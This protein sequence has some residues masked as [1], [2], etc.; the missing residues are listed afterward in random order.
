MILV[1][2]LGSL[3]SLGSVGSLGSLRIGTQM[4]TRLHS[5]GQWQPDVTLITTMAFGLRWPVCQLFS[6]SAHA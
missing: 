1:G 5:D 4:A 3:G 2:S 6:R